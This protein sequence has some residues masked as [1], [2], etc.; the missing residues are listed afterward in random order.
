MAT[1]ADLKSEIDTVRSEMGSLRADLA[2]DLIETR[3]EITGVRKELGEQVVGLRRAVIEYHTSVIG[4]GIFI[5]DLEASPAASNSNSTY[6][7]AMR[8]ERCPNSQ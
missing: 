4:H 3:Q 8:A 1:E 5:S 2:S 6:C 7:Q